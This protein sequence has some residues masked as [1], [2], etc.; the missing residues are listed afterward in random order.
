VLFQEVAH[1]R[2]QLLFLTREL[3][4]IMVERF[5][6]ALG[7]HLELPGFEFRLSQDLLGLFFGVSDPFLPDLLDGHE[8]LP[9][10]ILALLH[11][12]QLLILPRQALAQAGILSDELFHVARHQ[13][14]EFV[15]FPRVQPSKP[16]RE[17]LL[18]D[19]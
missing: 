11:P 16:E 1:L 8:R 3:V 15:D 13:F 10:F 19:L 2:H 17:L 9:E 5:N 12:L 18:S 7:L 6:L 14:E 4:Q